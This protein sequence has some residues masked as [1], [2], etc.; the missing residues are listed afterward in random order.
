MQ[1][2]ARNL[3]RVYQN[4]QIKA[5]LLPIA[6]A[7]NLTEIMMVIDRYLETHPDENIVLNIT[8]GTKPMAIAA[9]KSF[10]LYGKDIFYINIKTDELMF[11]SRHADQKVIHYQL[12]DKIG[13]RDYLNAYGINVI[14]HIEKHRQLQPSYQGLMQ[15]LVDNVNNQTQKNFLSSLN[16]YAS[17]AYRSLN[18]TLNPSDQSNSAFLIFLDPFIK[19]GLFTHESGQLNFATES[20]RFFCNGGWLED[21]L[22]VKLRSLRKEL[23]IQDIT[24]GLQVQLEKGSKNELDVVFI[25]NNR[26]YIIECKTKK[27]KGQDDGADDTVYK[28]DSL[29]DY[30]GIRTQAMLISYHE[31]K[32]VHKKRAADYNINVVSANELS[33]LNIHLKNWVTAS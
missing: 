20:S 6:D 21:Y 23:K 2:N 31:I 12:D 8:G 9:Q 27:Y 33:R 18:V 19:S 29:K 17:K 30:A 13:I 1:N 15:S 22:F 25:A 3:I 26:F 5:E 10:T 28:L 7:Y 11:L 16:Y 32:S 4:N 24:T 14:N